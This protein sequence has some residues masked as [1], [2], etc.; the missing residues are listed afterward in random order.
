MYACTLDR[1]IK[2]DRH[3]LTLFHSPATFATVTLGKKAEVG[4][5]KYL[6]FPNLVKIAHMSAKQSHQQV[7]FPWGRFSC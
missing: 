6:S 3:D 7:R 4:Y 5:L 2:R 1:A